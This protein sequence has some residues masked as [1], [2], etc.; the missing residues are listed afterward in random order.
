MRVLLITPPSPFLLDERVFPHIGILK[1]AGS[2]EGAGHSVDMMDLSNIENY[3]D[4]IEDY[5]KSTIEKVVVGITATTPQIPYAI[6]IVSVINSNFKSKVVKTILG[7]THVSLMHSAYKNELKK[8]HQARATINISKLQEYF[9]LLVCGDG[10]KA[11][12]Q[13]LTSPIGILDA[14]V[15]D[16]NLFLTD[17][18][19][20]TL[21]MPARH[22][23]D[24]P[25][26]NYS[27]EG[28]KA[29]S[30]I[31]QLGCPFM[32]SFC[33]GRNSP[34]LRKIR[35]RSVESVIDE[36][37][38]LH[39]TYGFTGFMFYDDELNVTKS[40]VP[41][42]KRVKELQKEL[43]TEFRLRGFVKSELFNKD[44]AE[45]MYDAGFRWLLTG[46]E[47]GDSRI[48][49]NIDK[50]ASIEDNT[51]CVEI[52]RNNGLKTKALMSIG[53]A[54]ESMDSIH[55]TK[56]WLLD[57]RPDDFDCTIITVYPGTP[58]YDE[59]IRFDD[60][61]YVYS[62]KKTG[63]RL[64]QK[65]MNFLDH[66]GYYKG[67]PDGG[68]VSYVWTDH[69]SSVELVLERDRLEAEVRGILN[70]PF[71]PGKPGITYEHSMGQGIPKFILKGTI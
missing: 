42:M 17:E 56:R 37:R 25:S 50:K 6:D 65:D 20:S 5:F 49:V 36:L 22:L 40:L 31:G 62:H 15:K 54:G 44:Q 14:D 38:F 11:I 2:L 58:Y 26:Y 13:A 19:F 7:G 64:Y 27:I 67:D 39:I 35:S 34:F 66:A 60:T 18:E 53:H 3:K 9:D 69:I 21:P 30:L 70:I 47:S 46:F 61:S 8:K 16:S 28:H 4:V 71:N 59:A 24:L 43:E 41:L 29:T 52:A 57:V 10:E 55:N 48:L 68:Y 1:V 32:C 63:D 45:S 23:I 12:H 51:K 33:G